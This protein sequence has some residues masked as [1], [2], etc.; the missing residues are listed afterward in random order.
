MIRINLLGREA[1]SKA[2]GLRGM[3]MPQLSVGASQAGIAALF[4]VVMSVLGLAFW[5]Q[6]GRVSELRREHATVQAEQAQLQE[7]ADEV[8]A[9]Q[10]R[11]DLLRQKLQV[12]VELKANQTGPVMLLDQVSRTLSD[13]LWLSQLQ[14]Q[15]GNVTMRGAA[16]S[17]TA[18]VQFV[19]SLESSAYF[20]EVRLRT[21]G[22]TGDTLNFQIFLEFRPVPSA[23]PEGA[24]AAGGGG[25]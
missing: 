20:D 17:E 2:R 15:R 22:D 13:G 21:L 8:T 16:L 12:I 11:T 23:T 19:D 18:V 24:A 25:N 4:V 5:S 10:D 14:L 1:E 7:I 3:Q 6:N 9:L